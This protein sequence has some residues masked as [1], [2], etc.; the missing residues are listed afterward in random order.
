MSHGR[1]DYETH[2][3]DVQSFKAQ[4]F[5]CIRPNTT[6][7]MKL[8]SSTPEQRQRARERERE[9]DRQT[10]I[11]TNI[12]DLFCNVAHLLPFNDENFSIVF[13]RTE[14]YTFKQWNIAVTQCPGFYENMLH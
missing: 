6:V 10:E 1:G 14:T 12:L 9:T 2:I 7:Q 11:Y 8:T 3:A 13:Q 5:T 4:W